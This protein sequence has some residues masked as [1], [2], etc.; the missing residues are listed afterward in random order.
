MKPWQTKEWKEMRKQLIGGKCE[1][2]GTTGG[3]FV[4]QHFAHYDGMSSPPSKKYIVWGIL[5]ERGVIPPRPTIERSACPKCEYRSL[6]ERRR[7]PTWRCIRCHNEFDDPLIVEVPADNRTGRDEFARYKQEC[8]LIVDRFLAENEDEADD[9]YRPILEDYEKERQASYN[10]YISGEDTASF[11]KKCAFQ[12]DVKE[13][14]LCSQCNERYHP[15]RYKN[16]FDCLPSSR[17]EEIHG[18]RVFE[19]EMNNVMR[20]LEEAN[21]T[22]SNS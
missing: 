12:W 14:K 17:K 19:E 20:E 1:Q 22:E 4:L 7:K 6:S 5:A 3:P 18:Y 16:C 2:C 9:L 10:K 13:Q 11:C 8:N 15:F 21:N